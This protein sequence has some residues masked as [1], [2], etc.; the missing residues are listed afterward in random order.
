MRQNYI[1]SASRIVRTSL[2]N[3]EHL[4]VV[5]HRDLAADD[6]SYNVAYHVI[7]YT[8]NSDDTMSVAPVITHTVTI[9]QALKNF[10][11]FPDF[12]R[13]FYTEVAVTRV[14]HVCNS[15]TNMHA[16]TVED[17]KREFCNKQFSMTTFHTSSEMTFGKLP[18][19]SL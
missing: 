10:Q 1:G 6:F 5:S 15:I 9:L 11:R 4:P 14:L 16:C 13:H 19:L 8:T 12:S 7:N 17:S 3:L 2:T 18:D